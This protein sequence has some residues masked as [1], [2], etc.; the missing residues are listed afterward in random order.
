MEEYQEKLKEME[1]REEKTKQYYEGIS[2][3][4]QEKLEER[5]NEI[6]QMRS[7]QKEMDLL[8]EKQIEQE[9]S[10][11]DE[12]NQI[13][14]NQ[15]NMNIKGFLRDLISELSVVQQGLSSDS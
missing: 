3:S 8:G 15:T 5:E 12:L 4:L 2:R 14:T 6:E 13:S 7:S 1:L 11:L 9:S 10:L